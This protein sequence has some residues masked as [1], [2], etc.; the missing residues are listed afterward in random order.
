MNRLI[1]AIAVLA[2]G[3]TATY[4]TAQAGGGTAK[5]PVTLQNFNR[6]ETDMYF[7]NFSKQ[8]AFGK[9]YHNREPVTVEKQDVIR[10]NRDTIYSAAVLDLDAGP[11]TITLPDAGKRYMALL[12]VNEDAYSPEVVYAP[13][14]F[15]Y[16]KE[17]IGTRYMCAIIRTLVDPDDPKDIAVV[18]K[19]QDS[20]K[21]AQANPGSLTV[22]AWDPES[23]K[24]IRDALKILAGF[25]GPDAPSK[26]GWMGEVDPIFH[27][28]GTAS[29]WGGNPAS[30]AKYIN[31]YPSQNSGKTIYKLTVKDVPVDG[32]WSITVYDKDGYFVKNDLGVYSIN[33][34]TA[35]PSRD[36]SVT[37]QF[38]G[39]QKDT[40]NCVPTPPDWNYTVRMYRPRKE[41]LDGTWKFPE[42]QPVK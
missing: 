10:S 42:A 38:G 5:V 35:K 8:G 9:F 18:Q 11:V 1:H 12:I 15:T 20:I 29:G 41:I 19:L 32:F 33:N 28:V 31:A 27:I 16:T 14:T 34:L 40:P 25:Q 17:K 4:S 7:S 23:Q 6:A 13:G 30:A 37:V 22:P 2:L 21:I 3:L 36:G 39:C 24:K 26:F